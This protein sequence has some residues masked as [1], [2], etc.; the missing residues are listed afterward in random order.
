M[1]S[2]QTCLASSS[3]LYLLHLPSIHLSI[4]LSCLPL[5]SHFPSEGSRLF[6]LSLLQTLS[7]QSFL[8]SLS[9]VIPSSYLFTSIFFFY[10]TSF[11]FLSSFLC[12]SK[13]AFSAF[14]SCHLPFFVCN[15]VCV[16]TQ[17]HTGASISAACLQF[18]IILSAL[19]GCHQ[20]P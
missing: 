1:L 9:P 2:L 3:D 16:C 19:I 13:V 11:P 14:S 17:T 20:D 5:F 8:L 10:P 6:V 4:H 18:I 7:M 12:I 15:C